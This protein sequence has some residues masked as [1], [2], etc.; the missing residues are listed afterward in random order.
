MSMTE[1]IVGQDSIADVLRDHIRHVV[2]LR[3]LVAERKLILDAAKRDWEDL[4]DE[5]IRLLQV[6]RADLAI[7]E[8]ALRKA[9]V[10]VFKVTG[11]KHPAQGVD[12]RMTRQIAYSEEDA[13]RWAINHG[14][15]DLLKLKY[16]LFEKVAKVLGLDF[17][18]VTE[19]PA[20]TIARELVV[21]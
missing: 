15:T 16:T 2:N 17:V 1:K 7:A 14:H 19:V 10:E 6:R 9:T 11:N 8:D 5:E 20:V 13:I 3:E 4:H 18:T 21:E 12:V